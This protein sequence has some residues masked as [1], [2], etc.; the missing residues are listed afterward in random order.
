MN[1][2]KGL[3]NNL[4]WKFGERILAQLVTF[5]VSVVLARL[6]DPSDY[7]IISMVTI[8]INIANLFVTDGFGSALI[9]KKDA[10]SKDFST[11]F[12]FNILFS[13][14]LYAILFVAAPFVPL[15]FGE[16]YEI[17]TPVLRVLGLR[18]IISSI[19][20]V[21]SAYVSRQMD[22]KKFFFSTLGS[23]I[24]SGIVGITMA[25]K[26]YGV[27]AL[28]GQYLT[29]V[30]V[31]TVVLFFTINWRP[32]LEFSIRRLK[33]LFN[34]GVKILAAVL[35]SNVYRETSA[36][37]IGKLYSS[38]DLAF[39][40]K[41]KQVPELVSTN[42]TASLSSVLFPKLSSIQ[43]DKTKLK[44][45]TQGSVRF[46]SYVLSPIMLGI[47][48]ISPSFVE[49]LFTKKWM[50]CIPVLQLFCV[51]YL[52][53]PI[54]VA[55]AQAIRAIGRSDIYLKLEIIKKAIEIIVLFITM[56]FGVNWI[57]IGMI[58]ESVAFTF[59]NAKPN[60][61]LLDYKFFEQIRDVFSPM[62]MALV[63]FVVIYAINYLN[64]SLLV[65]LSLQIVLGI[66][67]YVLES[68]IVKSPEFINILRIVS[69]GKINLEEK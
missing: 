14:L 18:I 37:I 66:I 61:K 53:Y 48:A 11:V 49:L 8:F 57:V 60:S 42:I 22:F 67:I 35:L 59:V 20:T 21:Q 25:L 27:W 3:L 68:L 7:G 1:N 44:L 50:D 4:F 33:V 17:L 39:Y 46:G 62:L 24:F 45:I 58:I 63:M 28:V 9:Q 54:H 38:N 64:I 65:K 13:F 69:K 32:T 29:N 51:V 26:G 12:Y 36:L 10:D 34:Y 15:I 31:G 5:V 43:D 56:W 19:N 2:Q 6:L 40:T 16:E 52:F 41:G 30:T 23:T 47:A 55:N